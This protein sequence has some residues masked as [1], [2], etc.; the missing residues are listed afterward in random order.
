MKQYGQM[1]KRCFDFKGTSSQNEYIGALIMQ[2]LLC[3]LLITGMFLLGRSGINILLIILYFC[4]SGLYLLVS[5]IAFSALTIRRL[6]DAG[7]SGWLYLLILIVGIGAV[8]LAVICA[9]ATT[10]YYIF[11]DIGTDWLNNNSNVNVYG[12][13]EWYQDNMNYTMYGPPGANN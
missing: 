12:P 11:S 7:K 3:I 2:G 8:I 6:H 4:I 9:M 1:W 10:G 5:T 13:P